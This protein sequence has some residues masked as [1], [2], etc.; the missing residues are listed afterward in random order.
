MIKTDINY[1]I[2][3]KGGNLMEVP[4]AKQNHIFI[5]I[6]IISESRH[7]QKIII[8]IQQGCPENT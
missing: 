1:Q 3:Y 6:A 5:I 7:T 8:N 4:V 2:K